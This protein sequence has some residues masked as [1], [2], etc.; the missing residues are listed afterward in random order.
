VLHGKRDGEV[1]VRN[2]KPKIIKG[3]RDVIDKKF[4][5]SGQFKSTEE[6]V[7]NE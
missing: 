7:F 3:V 2:V 1:A 5:S 6:A 4:A